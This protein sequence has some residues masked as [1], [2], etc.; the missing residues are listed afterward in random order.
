M[1][2]GIKNKIRIEICIS[3]RYQK[4][5]SLIL[6]NDEISKSVKELENGE[7]KPD[8]TKINSILIVTT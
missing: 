3:G 2:C 8:E 7:R 4:I 5:G 1:Q 6:N